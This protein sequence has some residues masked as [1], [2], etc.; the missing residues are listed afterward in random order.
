MKTYSFEKLD[1]WNKSKDFTLKIYDI[2]KS[3]PDEEKFGLVSQLRR[4]SVSIA[5]N[6]AEG[7]SRNSTKDQQRYYT[8]SYS[9]T[10]EVLNQLIISYELGFIKFDTYQEMRNDL[11]IITKMINALHNSL[12]K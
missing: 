10:I 6:I 12:N 11:E 8:I 7:S 2:T 1:V 9:T 3:F 4:A 5:S